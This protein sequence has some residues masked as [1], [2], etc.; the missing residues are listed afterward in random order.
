MEKLA[1]ERVHDA[2]L[3]AFLRGAAAQH[4]CAQRD[5]AA[6]KTATASTTRTGTGAAQ[7]CGLR[8]PGGGIPIVEILATAGSLEERSPSG[9]AA[10]RKKTGIRIGVPLSV[11]CMA[12]G[13]VQLGIQRQLVAVGVQVANCGK[14]KSFCQRLL[15]QARSTSVDS[16]GLI[17]Q[18]QQHRYRMRLTAAASALLS[19]K[20]PWVNRERGP[21]D[22]GCISACFAV[23]LDQQH[24]GLDLGQRVLLVLTVRAGKDVA[25]L[26]ASTRSSLRCLVAAAGWLAR[27]W[28]Y[29][30]W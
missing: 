16:G 4:R 6:A 5:N 14:E 25:K 27:C 15:R 19:R 11:N 1:D 30:P 12:R 7:A 22:E 9:R 20:Y 13:Q 17:L 24:G 26:S 2:V 10:E 8:Q 23:L 21:H 29:I 3:C 28:R 18:G